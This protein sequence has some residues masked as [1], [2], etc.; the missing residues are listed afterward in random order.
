M[1]GGRTMVNEEKRP[2]TFADEGPIKLK[3]PPKACELCGRPYIPTGGNAK[4]CPRCREL[5]KEKRNRSLFSKH[6]TQAFGWGP[7]SEDYETVTGIVSLEGFASSMAQ[8]A[9]FVF[10]L[11]EEYGVNVVSVRTS[12]EYRTEYD[13]L[14]AVPFVQVRKRDFYKMFGD[15]EYEYYHGPNDYISVRRWVGNVLF[16][17]VI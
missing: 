7:W 16:E 9:K 2:V 5:S 17:A 8:V 11:E 12:N 15:K 1:K 14:E 13:R 10:N 4:Y 6:A 3:I